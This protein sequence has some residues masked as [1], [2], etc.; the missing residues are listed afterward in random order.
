MCRVL[1]SLVAGLAVAGLIVRILMC[2]IVHE[3]N[4]HLWDER[5]FIIDCFWSAVSGALLGLLLWVAFLAASFA[6]GVI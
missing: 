5:E 4:E 2:V 3:W 1:I 6:I